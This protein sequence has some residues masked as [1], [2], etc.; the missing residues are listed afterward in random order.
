[1]C[2]QSPHHHSFVLLYSIFKTSPTTRDLFLFANSYGENDEAIY[3]DIGFLIHSK[4]V[5][6]MV[7]TC[8]GM[9]G[10]DMEPVSKA[11]EDLGARHCQYNIM[12]AHY[13]ILGAALLKTLETV[14]GDAWTP[15][16]KEAW[17]EIFDFMSNAMQKGA[18]EYLDEILESQLEEI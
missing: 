4:S 7:D 15:A 14:L 11:L 3:K 18:S 17:T 13:P 8:V 2:I 6:K 1:M 9:M 16:V 5:I 12:D 10:P